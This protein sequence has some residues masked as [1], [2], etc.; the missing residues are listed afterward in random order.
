MPEISMNLGILYKSNYHNYRLQNAILEN[1]LRF[2]E[3]HVILEMIIGLKK[4][5]Q[6][7][8]LSFHLKQL[9]QQSSSKYGPDIA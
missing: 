9:I 7:R 8:S 5:T 4:V 3:D 6:M 1:N 2:Q